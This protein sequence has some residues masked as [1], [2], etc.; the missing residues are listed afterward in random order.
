[1]LQSIWDFLGSPQF[2]HIATMAS[3]VATLVL[4]PLYKRLSNMIAQ[5]KKIP[6]IIAAL[7]DI[8]ERV[9]DL[10]THR[11][12]HDAPQRIFRWHQPL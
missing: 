9:T 4:I 10:E 5:L 1:M 12:S 8:D 11:Q 7:N 6:L 3:L 2:S